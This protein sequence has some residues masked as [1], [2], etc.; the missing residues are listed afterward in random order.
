MKTGFWVSVIG[1]TIATIAIIALL[2]YVIDRE[3]L[4]RWSSRGP[5]MALSTAVEF[6]LTGAAL[7]VTGMR[8]IKRW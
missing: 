1:V 8:F 6:L 3:S 5:A 4:H 7:F 2:G